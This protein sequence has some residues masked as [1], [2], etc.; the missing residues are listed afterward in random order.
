MQTRT[1]KLSSSKIAF[2]TPENFVSDP[3]GFENFRLGTASLS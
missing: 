3:Q 1:Y 2:R